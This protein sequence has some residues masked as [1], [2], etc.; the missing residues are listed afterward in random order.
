AEARPEIGRDLRA[1]AT[2]ARGEVGELVREARREIRRT[3]AEPGWVN[4]WTGEGSL[5]DYSDLQ[6]L[7]ERL[8][9]MGQADVLL[10]LA[11]TLF[12]AGTEQVGST[13]DEGE[14]ASA[15]A[16]CLAVAFRA[17]P[18]SS[19]TEAQNLLFAIDVALRD[20]YELCRGIDEFLEK[21]HPKEAW[22]E[23]ADVL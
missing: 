8:L 22:A 18:A 7:F 16:E 14:A 12:E 20:E 10:E 11:E 6:R 23:V 9:E 3:T 19:R 1:R 17:L 5:P 2:L 13:D 15:L 21:T 4:K